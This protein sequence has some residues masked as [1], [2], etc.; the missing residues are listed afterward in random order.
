MTSKDL[1]TSEKIMLRTESEYLVTMLQLT[2]LQLNT[3]S[4]IKSHGLEI[5][6]KHGSS[7]LNYHI[8]LAM[9]TTLIKE[10]PDT[11]SDKMSNFIKHSESELTHISEIIHLL[12]FILVLSFLILLEFNSQM[13]SLSSFTVVQMQVTAETPSQ[14]SLMMSVVPLAMVTEANTFAPTQ[15]ENTL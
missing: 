1:L 4:V 10:L 12:Q 6:E 14:M 7:N 15:M 2:V 9:R 8:V 13:H 5:M 3:H 11:E